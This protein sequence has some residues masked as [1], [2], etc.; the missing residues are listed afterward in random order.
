MPVRW[1]Y[2]RKDG[3]MV[4]TPDDSEWDD[5]PA[6]TDNVNPLVGRFAFWADDESTKINYN[7]AWSRNATLNTQP[8]GS[9]HP[10]RSARPAGF[11]RCQRE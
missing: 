1:V 5:L 10:R 6:A 4:R 2:I 7:L 8:P 9:S 3:T 11:Q